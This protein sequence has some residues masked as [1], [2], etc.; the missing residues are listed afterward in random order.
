ML[1]YLII[2]LDDSSVSFCHYP[3]DCSKRKLIPLDILNRAIIWAMKENLN[4]QF[5]YPDY[6]LPESYAD[7][8][9]KI[10]HTN[11]VSSTYEDNTLRNNADI[12]VFSSFEEVQSQSYISTQSYILRTPLCDLTKNVDIIKSILHSVTRLNIV[13]SDVDKFSTDDHDSYYSFLNTISEQIVSEYE[14]SHPVQLNIL[15]DR[16]ML[17]SMNNCGA[18][19][20]S[21]TLAPDGKFYVCPGFYVD[22]SNSVG[23]IV[24]GLNVINPQLYTL[25]HA[26]ICSICD[27]WHC[28]RCVWLNSKLTLEVN[29]PGK[30]QCVVAHIEREAS[31]RLLEKIRTI[32]DFMPDNEI[33]KLNYLDPFEELLKKQR[34]GY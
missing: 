26:P 21:L 30:E 5:L 27:A 32:G 28:K 31:R 7:S 34:H 19:I 13:L 12:V 33:K 29:T 16:I 17:G 22:G 15:T 18:G 1:K 9:G 25:E 6:V 3:N 4:V 14:D 10:E 24:N 23:D 11:I 2:Q 20:E 8:I